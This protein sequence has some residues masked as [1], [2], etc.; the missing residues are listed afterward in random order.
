MFPFARLRIG[1]TEPDSG[2]RTTLG[3]ALAPAQPVLRVLVLF[4]L[5]PAMPAWADRPS[6]LLG[7]QM[8]GGTGTHVDDV[9]ADRH[10]EL[11]TFLRFGRLQPV[12]WVSRFE[13]QTKDSQ[14]MLTG[15]GY[16]AGVGFLEDYRTVMVELAAGVGIRT[17]DT[18]C[19]I[20][21]G[22]Q[23][24]VCG[25]RQSWS[26]QLRLGITKQHEKSIGL[27]AAGFELVAERVEL[28]PG[29]RG[30]LVLAGIVLTG[31]LRLSRSRDRNATPAVVAGDL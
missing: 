19:A 14:R 16:G 11:R 25:P 29:S 30:V 1:R 22:E 21:R 13:V 6:E 3:T 7:L 12:A 5:L 4:A 20:T 10:H 15:F 31:G 28:Q 17:L 24:M 8:F 9:D 18:D 2:T 23:R 27:F 26:P